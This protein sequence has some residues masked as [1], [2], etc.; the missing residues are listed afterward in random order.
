LVLEVLSAPPG[1][2]VRVV[3]ALLSLYPIRV[4]PAFFAVVAVQLLCAPPLAAFV[5]SQDPSHQVQAGCIGRTG[6]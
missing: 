6:M 5:F 3:N 2:D 4:N 1:L